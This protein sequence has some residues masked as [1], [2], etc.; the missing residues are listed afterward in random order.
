M[1]N[2]FLLRFIQALDKGEW[3][4][5]K[6]RLLK[7]T[8]PASE[9][10]LQIFDALT[11]MV[12]NSQAELLASLEDTIDEKSLALQKTR[13]YRQ[14]VDYLLVLHRT[15][16]PAK[17]PIK[18]LEEARVL[19]EVG[20]LNDATLVL[21]TAITQ[22]QK[23][24]DLFTEVTLRE[25]LRECYKNLDRDKNQDTITQNEYQLQTAVLKLGRLIQY[26]QINDRMW[27]YSRKH[28]LSKNANI[29][30]ARQELV[31]RPEM[32]DRNLADSLP[33]QL[34]YFNVWNLQHSYNGETEKALECQKTII[35]LYEANPDY[36]AKFPLFYQTALTNHIGKLIMAGKMDDCPKLLKKLEKIKPRGRREEILYFQ[37]AEPH[38]QLYYMNT[39]QL[40]KVIKR[41]PKILKGL[42]RYGKQVREGTRVT[43]MYNLGVSHLISGKFRNALK[44]FNKLRDFGILGSRQDLQGLARLFRLVL[45]CDNDTSGG[46]EHYLRN[47]QRFFKDGNRSFALENLIYDWLQT[48]HSIK[49]DGEKRQSFKTLV[50]ELEPLVANRTIGA[51]EFL[52]YARAKAERRDVKELFLELIGK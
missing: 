37:A 29:D 10:R 50:A 25:L 18:K 6:D 42:S 1:T 4:Y 21:Q 43:L 19:M 40:E 39:G 8:G 24:E 7:E 46:F 13:L 15:R 27:D 35:D 11:K 47:G 38:F 20:M 52:L 22:A 41:E 49:D 45:I 9:I 3:E 32:Q 14:L 34:R 36:I 33:A 16:K 44:V 12:K 51:E 31:S 30:K 28:R 23:T 26:T 48:H 5:C 2:D 17:D